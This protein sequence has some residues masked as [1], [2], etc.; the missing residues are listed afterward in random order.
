[1]AHPPAIPADYS[2]CDVCVYIMKCLQ[3]RICHVQQHKYIIHII[4][5]L[6]ALIP[7][8]FCQ[9]LYLY[10]A[11]FNGFKEALTILE[12]KCECPDSLLAQKV[13]PHCWCPRQALA[14]GEH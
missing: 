11:I 9:H 13:W 4:R 10:V 2:D 14:Q 8:G 7:N 12:A 1:M 3:I 6:S 5:G